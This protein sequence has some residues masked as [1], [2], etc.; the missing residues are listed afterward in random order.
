[1]GGGPFVQTDPNHSNL[2]VL[3]H[4]AK[5]QFDVAHSQQKVN[6]LHFKNNLDLLGGN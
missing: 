1:M 2:Q 6:A 5:P 3:A 4:R